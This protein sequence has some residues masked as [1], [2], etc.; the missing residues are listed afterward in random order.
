MLTVSIHIMYI[1]FI[2]QW[3]KLVKQHF[4]DYIRFHACQL[5]KSDFI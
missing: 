1:D 5:T 3:R 4:F 2:Q